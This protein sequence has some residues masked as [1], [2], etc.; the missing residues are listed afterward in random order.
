[1]ILN[2]ANNVTFRGLRF[3]LPQTSFASAGGS[4]AS[5]D[6]PAAAGVSGSLVED[7]FV[8]IGLRPFHCALLSVRD[9]LFRFTVTRNKDC[10]G[11]GI[12]AASECWGLR[13][14]GNRFLRDEDTLR[15]VQRPLR[16]FIGY[17]LAPAASLKQARQPASTLARIPAGL[18]VR[19]LLQDA[20]IEGNL[21]SGLSACILVY[22]NT[23]VVRIESNTVRECL[24]GFWLLSLRSV[25]YAALINR[26]SVRNEFAA[27]A[28]RLHNS[29]LGVVLDPVIQIGSVIARIYPLPAQIDLSHALQVQA[30]RVPANP[31]KDQMLIQNVFDRLMPLFATAPRVAGAPTAAPAGA[32][33]STAPAAPAAG[34]KAGQTNVSAAAGPA[35]ERALALT[36]E[37]ARFSQI[38]LQLSAFERQALATVPEHGFPLSLHAAGND[39]Q[40]LVKRSASGLGLIVW[41][42]ERDTASMA[43][44]NSNKMRSESPS[45]PTAMLLLVERCAVGANLIF[46]EQPAV[47]ERTQPNPSLLMYTGSEVPTGGGNPIAPSSV[48][49]NVFR[50]ATLLPPRPVLVPP[51]PPPM[52][53]WHFFNT[54]L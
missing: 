6:Q 26:V 49:G 29:I 5:F 42:D 53:T 2:R 43:T 47:S 41:D 35:V 28:T 39:I 24:S 46:N 14:T 9:C 44:L 21:F 17:L 31:S 22:G 13:L 15:S 37:L 54:E 52:D 51:A 48:T 30:R 8:S 16:M 20:I 18:L 10:F 3:E 36:G 38:H 33:P 34:Q 32:A 1:V 45:I 7:L 12:F 25:A 11:V 23:G 4:L 27:F 40:L 19:S 50:G